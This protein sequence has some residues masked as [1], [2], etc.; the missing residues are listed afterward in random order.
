MDA[1]DIA[2][3][4]LGHHPNPD[5]SAV[6]VLRAQEG[7]GMDLPLQTVVFTHSAHSKSLVFQ[8]SCGEDVGIRQNAQPTSK[9]GAGP[10]AGVASVG[11]GAGQL[12]E[13][14]QRPQRRVFGIQPSS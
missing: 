14:A 12:V 9:A 4:Q 8:G 5:D 2:Q 1:E 3:L 13:S 6:E 11:V 10:A 7:A